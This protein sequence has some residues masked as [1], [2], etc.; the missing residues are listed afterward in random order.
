MQELLI[1]A[2]L[3][4]IVL[5]LLQLR[6]TSDW[7]AARFWVASWLL[8]YVSA[9]FWALRGESPVLLVA[10]RTLQVPFAATMLAGC[11][12]FVGR[13]IPRG[14]WLT[15]AAATAVVPG[16]AA[17]FGPASSLVA[18]VTVVAPL[19]LVASVL[20][21]RHAWARRASWSE[22]SLGPAL[23]V[24]G[25]MHLEA[26]AYL[27]LSVALAVVI[28]IL[29][30]TAFLRRGYRR[31][32]RQ[33]SER[34][35]L[36]RIALV[37]ADP[38]D[39]SAALARATARIADYGRFSMLGIW[40]IGPAGDWHLLEDPEHPLGLP[41][42]LHDIDADQPM[43]LAVVEAEGPWFIEDLAHDARALPAG[44]GAVMLAPLRAGSELVGVLCG[45]V[46]EGATVDD[47]TR[48]F[49]ADLAD[50]V[51]LVL[52]QI[53]AR[54]ERLSQARAIEAE[55]TTMR[56]ILDNSPL[57]V[58]L[59]SSERDVRLVNRPFAEHLGFG[60]SEV[61]VGCALEE[62]F[63]RVLPRVAP[64]TLPGARAVLR[65]LPASSER[66]L[67]ETEVRTLPP[68]ERVL[69]C[70]SRIVRGAEDRA[71]GRV[72]I[73]RD[74]TA[75]RRMAQR[76]QHA[77]RMETLGTLAGGLAH[78]FNNQLTAILGNANLLHAALPEGGAQHDALADLELSAEHC[79]DLTRGLLD[80]ARQSPATL[81]PVDVHRVMTEAASLLRPTFPPECALRLEVAPDT[82]AVLADEVQL[83]RV[84]TN[85]LVNARD[86]AGEVGRVSVSA[87]RSEDA[88]DAWVVLEVADD[89]VGMDDSTRR[90]IF[91][92]FFTTKDVGRG[93][94]LGLSVVYG[95][96]DAHGGSIEVESRVGKGTTFSV[97]WPATDEQVVRPAQARRARVAAPQARATV[98]VAED[99][100][101]V[102]R[103]VRTTL[104]RAG[105]HVIE[106]RDGEEAVQHFLLHAEEVDV[107]LF[108]LSMPRRTGLDALREIRERAPD[109]PALI[110]SGHPD[111]DDTRAWPD[112]TL[113]LPKPF[114]PDAL[115]E[116]IARAMALQPAHAQARPRTEA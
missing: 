80:F 54:E 7:L 27:G 3:F 1:L 104:E 100:G 83:R 52:A 85:L 58:L 50:E 6:N 48:V 21:T 9:L 19:L 39:P 78:D 30:L 95:I 92:P 2:P 51:A 88:G 11:L 4:L 114:A 32:A 108:D 38:V 22:R 57:G 15:T 37:L 105:Y 18:S 62:V 45:V 86:A 14:F 74:V 82:G 93:T 49:T 8:L 109:L 75:E 70:S 94:G 44:R 69:V 41:P 102:R 81:R 60:D 29:Q 67:P 25:A 59:A 107:A 31:E 72:W 23:L 5:P 113:S 10:A 106:A 47:E 13:R 89:G 61:L 28:N 71:L 96:V 90:R 63:T 46:P 87:R 76:L 84:L 99:E 115:V 20:V 34:E 43:G 97:R 77:E 35:F 73:T 110:M 24:M 98:L 66:E 40:T 68:D 56:E 101:G 112:R 36:R 65:S 111:R 42:E 17:A 91:D 26:G 33:R 16:A 103:L 116:A 64:A 79:A 53:R 12:P 55:R